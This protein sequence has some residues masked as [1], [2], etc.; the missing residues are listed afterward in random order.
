MLLLDSAHHH[1]QVLR[2]NDYSDPKWIDGIQNGL[3]NLGC[4]AFLYLQAASKDVHQSWHFTKSNNF[5]SRDIG[6]VSLA[7]EGQ[8]MMFAQ[9]E[10][11]NIPYDHHLVVGYVDHSI[12][13]NFLGVLSEP[14][15]RYCSECSKRSRVLSKPSRS[16]LHKSPDSQKQIGVW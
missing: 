6:V 16:G 1:A 9:T 14:L 12:E 11:F 13:E 8:N 5:S 15:V 2:F 3:C 4:Q 7:E 10:R